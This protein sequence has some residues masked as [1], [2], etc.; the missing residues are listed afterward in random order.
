MKRKPPKPETPKSPESVAP[1][2]AGPVLRA[3]AM[4]HPGFAPAPVQNI[5]SKLFSGQP[6]PEWLA[7]AAARILVE[8]DSFS[9]RAGRSTE[10]FLHRIIGGTEA[11]AAEDISLGLTAAYRFYKNAE[12]FLVARNVPTIPVPAFFSPEEIENDCVQ[13]ERACVLITGEPKPAR[14][15]EKMRRYEDALAWD[16]IGGFPDP[17][18]GWRP[19]AILF[20]MEDYEDFSKKP[21]DLEKSQYAPHPGHNAKPARPKRKRRGPRLPKLGQ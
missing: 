12:A 21:L 16:G 15:M 14:A 19:R 18:E 2:K 11:E 10:A 7:D 1:A 4:N 13:Y 8:A 20:A 3:R 17:S 6:S 9:Q 5:P